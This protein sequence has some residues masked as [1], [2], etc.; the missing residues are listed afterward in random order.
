MPLRM[1]IGRGL[2]VTSVVVFLAG[3]A[4]LIEPQMAAP[5]YPEPRFP[6]YLKPPRSVDDVM[7]AARQIVRN[8]NGI[9]GSGMGVLRSGDGVTQRGGDAAVPVPSPPRASTGARPGSLPPQRPVRAWLATLTALDA[10]RAQ[11]FARLD[12]AALDAVYKRGSRPWSADRALLAS[13]QERRV[14]VHGLQIQV[15]SVEVEQPYGDAVVLRVVDR[16]AGATAVD[17]AGRRI[18]LPAGPVTTRLIT[19]T[20]GAGHWRI[21]SIV[22]G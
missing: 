16:F 17:A 8:K 15:R 21:S 18:T 14:R 5:K 7:P 4:E 20:G 12:P 3:L 11:A 22:Q 9:Q 1:R 19:M 10:R 13:Y 6:D 2:A